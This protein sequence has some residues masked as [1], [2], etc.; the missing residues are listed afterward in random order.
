VVALKR[1]HASPATKPEVVSPTVG[2]NPTVRSNTAIAGIKSPLGN[3]SGTEPGK[4]MD[5]RGL[6]LLISADL[7]RL[8]TVVAS[9]LCPVS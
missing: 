5:E 7:T 2:A 6:S 1:Y 9:A 8:N 3:D 4:K